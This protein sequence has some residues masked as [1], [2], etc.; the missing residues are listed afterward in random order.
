MRQYRTPTIFVLVVLAV[1]VLIVLATPAGATRAAWVSQDR[2][3]VPGLT[4]AEIRFGV[5]GGDD[6][7]TLTNSSGFGLAYRPALAEVRPAGTGTTAEHLAALLA[8]GPAFSYHPGATECSGAAGRWTATA[9]GPVDPAGDSREPLPEGAAETLCLAVAPA[10]GQDEALRALHGRQFD[11]V[12]TLEAVPA[13]GGSW[14]RTDSSWTARY[15]VDAPPAD[16]QPAEEPTTVPAPAGRCTADGK[17]AVLSWSWAG[18][19][20]P[21]ATRWE[22]L[23]RPGT[24][25]EWM[26]LRL[27]EVGAAPE[28]RL[29][30]LDVPEIDRGPSK[31]VPYEFTVRPHLAQ[32]TTAQEGTAPET[33][34]PGT[35]LPV[36]T[37]VSPGNSKKL[38]C[39]AVRP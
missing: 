34:A 13:G 18:G 35:G 32:G 15:V 21:A 27:V 38:E 19:T 5:T 12:T 28:A 16:E 10:A 29:T 36:W 6:V 37:L 3:D 22:V 8:T 20:D 2:V 26:S 7:A 39:Q 33:A 25:G 17:D 24:G 30:H 4:M 1:L 23:R 14:S 31:N 11:V 9:G